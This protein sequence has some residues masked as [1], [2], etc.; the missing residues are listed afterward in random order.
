MNRELLINILNIIYNKE[1]FIGK[2]IVHVPKFKSLVNFEMK[3]IGS[4]F[5]HAKKGSL[6]V[7]DCTSH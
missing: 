7:E 3:T 4:A 2:K 5:F 6:T 1:I